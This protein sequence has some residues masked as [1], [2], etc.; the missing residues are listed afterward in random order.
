LRSA[1]TACTNAEAQQPKKIYRLGY[2]SPRPGVELRE[3]VFRQALRE[4]GYI[5]SQNLAIEWRFSKGRN[6][7]F[8]ELAAELVRLQLDCIV[9]RGVS[10]VDA[11]KQ[12]TKT[13]PIVIGTIDA[14]PVEQGFVASLARPAG[15]IIG[16]TGIAYDIAG[17]RLELLKETVPKASRGNSCR[18]NRYAS[19]HCQSSPAG[20][21][22]R[23]A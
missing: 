10:A 19:C 7:L 21:R 5:E 13:I 16:F 1:L 23:R 6:Q 17:K 18:S 8:P 11:L 4:L 2:L 14:D 12:L 22:D 20:D 9:A 15:N 3:E